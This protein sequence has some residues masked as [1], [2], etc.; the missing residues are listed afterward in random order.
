[1]EYR[2]PSVESSQRPDGADRELYRS[3][4]NT[5]KIKRPSD[6]A[7][8]ISRASKAT[9]AHGIVMPGVIR[10]EETA[11][12]LLVHPMPCRGT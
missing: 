7:L 1:M 6:V 4:E 3:C 5:L 11:F 9:N 12:R 8:A 2:F 10:F